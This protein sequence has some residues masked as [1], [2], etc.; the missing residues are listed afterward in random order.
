MDDVKARQPAGSLKISKK[1]ITAIA[2]TAA[3]EI[4]GVSSIPETE[5]GKS[6]IFSRSFGRSP[7]HIAL[8]DDFAEVEI[9]VILDSGARIPDVCAKIQA[10]VKDNIQTMTGI[11]VSKVNVTVAGVAFPAEQAAGAD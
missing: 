1:V 5:S 2:R 9:S 8:S 6:G 10:G 3:L 4:R 11:V 7:I